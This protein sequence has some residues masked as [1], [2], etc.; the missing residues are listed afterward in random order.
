MRKPTSGSDAGA[1]RPAMTQMVIG[2][3]ILAV[4]DTE[5]GL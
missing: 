2:K 5:R 3:R 1:T 4:F